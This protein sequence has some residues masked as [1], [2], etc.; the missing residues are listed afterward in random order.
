MIVGF[1]GI[2]FFGSIVNASMVNLAERQREVATFRAIGYSQW[3]I[4]AIFLR[5]SLLTN[6]AGALLGLPVGFFLTWITV[7]TYNNDLL[8]LPLVTAPWIWITTLVSA[9]V[10][11][12]AAQAVVQWTIHRMDYLEALKVKE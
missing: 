7:V 5:E 1:S 9:L 12:L 8:R 6:V 11:V 10:F 4:G 2:I 3:R